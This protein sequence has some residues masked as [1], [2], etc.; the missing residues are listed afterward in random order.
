M[1]NDKNV[2]LKKSNVLPFVE[3]RKA[4]KSNACYHT[5]SHD[6]FSFGVIDNGT[7]NYNNMHH[8]LSIG[9]GDTVTINPG[10]S[11]SC[12]PA[13]DDWSYRMLFVDA[14]WIGKTQSEIS[15]SSSQDYLHFSHSFEND[16]IFF[17]KFEV[18]F[19]S[20]LNESN[21]LH[22]ETLLIQFIEQCTNNSKEITKR[23]AQPN[24]AKVR[25]RLLDNLDLSHSLSDLSK[26]SGISR[27]HLLRSFKKR[28][29]CSPHSMLLDERI[30]KAKQILKAGS[31]LI[32][33]SSQLGFSDQS[34]FQRHFKKRLAM[35]PKQYQAFFL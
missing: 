26:E 23:E 28:Y 24:L 4:A 17:N 20:L 3:M 27:Y 18:L 33:A 34:H 6:E 8:R 10:D 22:S 1:L 30:K 7:A 11:H 35:T 9:T 21:E 29:G 25:E 32:E 16:Q 12:N 5:H 15:N 2:F 14:D 19:D 13:A 31:T